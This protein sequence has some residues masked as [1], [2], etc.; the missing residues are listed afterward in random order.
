MDICMWQTI[1]GS[2]IGAISAALITIIVEK[3][4]KP[5]LHLKI[6]EPMENNY[7][8]RPAKLKRAVRLQI[9]NKPLP[10]WARWMS[11]SPA[12][13][14]GGNIVFYHLDGQNVF[15]RSMIIR[16]PESPEPIPLEIKLGNEY[17][18]IVDPARMVLEQRKDVHPGKSELIDVACRFDQDEDCYGWNN[19]SYFSDPLWRNAN[20]KLPKGRYL[21]KANIAFAGNSLSGLFRLINDVDIHDFRMEKALPDDYERLNEINR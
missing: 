7:E 19:E 12:L 4:R 18:V 16:W 10:S 15:G 13:Q 5:K 17:G 21:V 1:L 11:R 14:C 2:I 3:L 20:W 6:A 9:E 8:D